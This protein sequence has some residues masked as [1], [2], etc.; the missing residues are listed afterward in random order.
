MWRLNLCAMFREAFGLRLDPFLDTADPSYYYE[1]LACAHGK[2]RLI[3][4]LEQGQ[5]L[6]VVVG[7]IGAG[8]T[9]LLNAVQEALLPSNRNV[10]ASILDPDFRDE[11]DLLAAVCAAFGMPFVS[12][13]GIRG[14]KEAFKRALFAMSTGPDRQAVLFIDE[15][16]ALR[17]PAL[18]CLRSL[19]NYQLDDRKLLSVVI[20]GQP[21]LAHNLQAQ[22]NLSDRIALLLHV[23]PIAESEAA[24]LLHHRLRKA[25]YARPD[26]P[27][28]PE[29]A[30][31]LWRLSGGLP[32]RLTN[33][34]RESMEEAAQ[35]GRDRVDRRDV[36]AADAR[37]LAN[38][39]TLAPSSVQGDRF[40]A[41][42]PAVGRPRP[43]W[44][45]WQRAS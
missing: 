31:M 1:T 32:R 6:A 42:E 40:Q 45:F 29:A 34:A 11:I 25:G 5:G 9:A 37:S 35:S 26:S 39:T 18:E 23:R 41:D 36:E 14:A 30:A 28:D 21:E 12:D 19:L 15:A 2:R 13:G 16:Q 44:A 24:G 38:V 20:A 8:K 17:P 4:C 33:L 10:I 27:F 3:E 22:P 7:A 43:W